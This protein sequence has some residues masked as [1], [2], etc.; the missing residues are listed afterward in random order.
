ME[1]FFE[2]IDQYESEIN[3]LRAS[4]AMAEAVR[5]GYF[6]GSRPPF[7]FRTRAVTVRESIVRHVLEPDESEAEIVREIF[8]LYITHGGAESVARTLNQRGLRYR[9][10]APWNKS[11]VLSV[12]EESAVIGTYTWGRSRSNPTQHDPPQSGS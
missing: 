9:T 4:A 11:L 1:G 8:R 12:L 5:Q 6:P 2:C 10:G 3:G 7:G